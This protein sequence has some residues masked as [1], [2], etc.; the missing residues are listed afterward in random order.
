[1]SAYGRVCPC[2]CA[3]YTNSQLLWKSI[4]EGAAVPL[5]ALMVKLIGLTSVLV[6]L[7]LLT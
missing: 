5:F 7:S 3:T 6:S 2:V 4:V 1:M